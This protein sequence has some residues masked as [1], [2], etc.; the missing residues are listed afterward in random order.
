[1]LI[2]PS[3]KEDRNFPVLKKF[4]LLVSVG[5]FELR[6]TLDVFSCNLLDEETQEYY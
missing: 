3:L 1:M 2:I 6:I 4:V 5:N